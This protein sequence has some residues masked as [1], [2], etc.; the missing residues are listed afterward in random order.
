MLHNDIVIP[1]D[2]QIFVT[3]DFK[4]YINELSYVMNLIINRNIDGYD[5]EYAGI[6]AFL[7]S[8]NLDIKIVIAIG[9]HFKTLYVINLT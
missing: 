4:S 6:C 8:C 9:Q 7:D 3:I 2:K 5:D 1:L